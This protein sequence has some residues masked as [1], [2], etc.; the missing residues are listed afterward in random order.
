LEWLEE[1]MEEE[2]AGVFL[3]DK[4]ILRDTARG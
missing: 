1:G 3:F 4:N 2:E